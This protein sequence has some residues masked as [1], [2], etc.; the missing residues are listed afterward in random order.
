MA[1]IRSAEDIRLWEKL[2]N[3]D[4]HAIST[5]F[6]KYYTPLLNYG[7]KL[8]PDESLVKDSIQELFYVLWE[9]REN[10]SE[11]EYIRSYLYVS[12]R[13]TVFRQAEIKK[14]RYERDKAYADEFFSRVV[15]YEELN[16]KETFEKEQKERLKQAL[17]SLSNKQKEA[18]FLK[19][20][21]G[22]TNTEI[23]QVMEVNR[24]SVYNYIYR[25]IQSLQSYLVE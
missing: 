16:R 3:G 7:L 8:I 2:Q 19:F 11:V 18:V 17:E 15:N 14:T 22:L 9:Q 6:E 4:K 1:G 12:L 21:S 25:A 20:Y 24:Q 5:L 13:R 23:A 10:L